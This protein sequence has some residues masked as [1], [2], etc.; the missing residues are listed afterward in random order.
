MEAARPRPDPDRIAAARQALEVA[1]RH[2]AASSPAVTSPDRS[3][4]ERVLTVREDDPDVRAAVTFVLRSTKAKPQTE[5]QLAD[6]LVTREYG[7]QVI[8]AAM[9][10]ARRLRA[11][12]DAALARAVVQEKGQGQ[13]WGRARV[14]V[15]LARRGVPEEIAQEALATL[16]GRDERAVATELARRRAASLPAQLTPDVVARRLVGYLARRGHS[17]GLAQRVAREVSGVDRYRGWD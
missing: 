7:P 13:G 5:W 6:K 8:A 14:A 1:S 15:D 16:D 17:Q 4:E 3:R 9:A 2:G 10:H 12:D 11:V